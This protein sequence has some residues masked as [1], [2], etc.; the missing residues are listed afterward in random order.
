MC[1]VLPADPEAAAAGEGRLGPLR[2][3]SGALG[4]VLSSA[5]PKTTWKIAS[6]GIQVTPVCESQWDDGAGAAPAPHCAL[7]PPGPGGAPQAGTVSRAG[8]SRA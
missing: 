3:G 8:L 7:C 4:P 2:V 1:P 5:F 6:F